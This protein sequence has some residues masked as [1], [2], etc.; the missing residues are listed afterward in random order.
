MVQHN[1]Y[2]FLKEEREMKRTNGI[3]GWQPQERPR[4]RLEHK[5]AFAL[6]DAE[7]IAIL[8]HT[9]SGKHTALDLAREVL[10]L[11]QNNL[12]T[13][14]Q[15][16]LGQLCS[17]KGIGKAK[18]LTLMAALELGRRIS[19]PSD[20][21]EET[22][23]CSTRT[24]ADI[25]IS[26]LCDLPHEECWVIFLNRANRIIAKEKV[27]SG[28]ISGTVLDLRL[29]LKSAVNRLASSI[30]LIHNHPSGYLLP[31]PDDRTQTQRLSEA[32]ALFGIILLDHIIVAQKRY[33]SFAEQGLLQ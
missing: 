26:L 9:G 13:L 2:I 12:S 22:N 5:G 10:A 14:G 31:G 17:I 24:A 8:L 7:I 23:V 32:A 3:L 16:N 27:S 1:I 33:Y 11:G 20:K 29:I 19:R 18:A 30:I 15:M 4:E 25:G 6:S 28:G 21:D